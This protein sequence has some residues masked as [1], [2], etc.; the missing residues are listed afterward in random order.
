MKQSH[1]LQGVY[2]LV[3]GA[4]RLLGLG[5]LEAWRHEKEVARYSSRHREAQPLKLKETASW[6]PF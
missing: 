1:T 5:F 3:R 6:F 4:Q 2:E